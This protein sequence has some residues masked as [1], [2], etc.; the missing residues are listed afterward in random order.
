MHFS[1]SILF[2]YQM[3]M[4]SLISINVVLTLSINI[5][6]SHIIRKNSSTLTHMKIFLDE[7]W[8]IGA[9]SKGYICV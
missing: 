4:H 7:F 1:N 8:I 5:L 6:I 9:I 2:Y 3:P